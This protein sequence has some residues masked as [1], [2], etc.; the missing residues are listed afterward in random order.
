MRVPLRVEED[1]RR[2]QVAVKDAPH[3]GVLDGF[4]RLDHQGHG[5][6]GI[7]LERGELLG[8]VAPIDQLH[9]EVALAVVLADFVHR[10]DAGVIQ[11]RDGLGLVLE[12]RSSASSASTP[13]LIILRATGRL[14]LTCRAL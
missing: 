8:E 1:V 6:P 7:V 3:V 11:Q 4:G 13:A 2:L 5:G 12:A 10:H 14:R 9:A